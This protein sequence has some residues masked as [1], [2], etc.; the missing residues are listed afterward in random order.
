MTQTP[1]T[2]ERRFSAEDLPDSVLDAAC[3]EYDDLTSRVASGET[4]SSIRQAMR[5]AAVH[6]LKA[7]ATEPAQSHHSPSNCS[8]PQIDGSD[9]K[10]ERARPK[11]EAQ[12]AFKLIS[13]LRIASQKAWIVL[14][15][16]LFRDAADWIEQHPQSPTR[17]ADE[18]A[19]GLPVPDWVNRET[20]SLAGWINELGTLSEHRD[21]NRFPGWLRNALKTIYYGLHHAATSQAPSAE[22]EGETNV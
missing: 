19:Q 2:G 21:S 11:E 4:T 3:R 8:S 17:P 7:A 9:G 1:A 13:G 5:R 14:D 20:D 16:Q 12:G 6:I 15:Q 22:R 10:A 18:P